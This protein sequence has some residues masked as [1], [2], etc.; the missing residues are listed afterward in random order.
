MSNECQVIDLYVYISNSEDS[1]DNDV[2]FDV[3]CNEKRHELRRPG[4][5][6]FRSTL[7]RLRKVFTH[8]LHS[9]G[10]SS[11]KG[12]TVLHNIIPS[13]NDYWLDFHDN[14]ADMKNKDLQSGMK[15]HLDH[16]ILLQV[17]RNAPLVVK[18]SAFPKKLI[19]IDR[20][21]VIVCEV[22]FGV[23][24]DCAW[25]RESKPGN[26]DYQFICDGAIYSPR[27]EDLCCKIKVIC[28]PWREKADDESDHGASDESSSGAKR[29]ER[30]FGRSYVLYLPG[31]VDA[32]P[33]PLNR[34]IALRESFP[35]PSKERVVSNPSEYPL[36]S[37]PLRVV[38]Y[39]IL[40]AGYG[41]GH[42]WYAD[43]DCLDA[44][45]RMQSVYAELESY[46]ADV[47][48]L[49][50]CGYDV[51]RY[52]FS[53]LLGHIYD[54]HFTNKDSGVLEGCACFIR[55]GHLS[56]LRK[57]DIS[58]KNILRNDPQL[59]TF[60]S[61]RP[62]LKDILGGKLGTIAQIVICRNE[63][64]PRNLFVLANTHLYYHE[65]ADYLR[66]LQLAAITSTV[67]RVVE[68]LRSGADALRLSGLGDKPQETF[69]ASATLNLE[70][71]AFT[72]E[73]DENKDSSEN[74]SWHSSKREVGTES[75][76]SSEISVILAG[77]LNSS[78]SSAVI[79]FLSK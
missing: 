76:C 33:S 34:M 68:D 10:K 38:S 23:G 54:S 45:Y 26:K 7:N 39:N 53:P 9:K 15:I 25:Y 56:I 51:F 18:I 17:I 37:F 67:E 50:E 48:C 32:L 12:H 14:F 63:L 27:V 28:T 24:S 29:M 74:G 66:L 13:D 77:D 8:P 30:L 78:P 42:Y 6:A 79:E 43:E 70:A 46:Q 11:R 69:G 3:I 65:K 47:I 44:E 52:Y 49:Q 20:P 36:S 73:N 5:N 58:L 31:A 22:Q 40:F 71:A 55:R 4:E 21:I 1:Q 2:I 41:Y 59:S 16:T 72:S 57:A 19:W 75:S 64:N 61:L 35:H 62:D 60:Y